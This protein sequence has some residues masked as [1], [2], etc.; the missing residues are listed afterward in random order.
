MNH[1]YMYTVH[2]KSQKL[3]MGTTLAVYVRNRLNK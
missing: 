1:V 3:E 2:G